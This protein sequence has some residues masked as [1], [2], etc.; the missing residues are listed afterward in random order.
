MILCF[1]SMMPIRAAGPA[2]QHAALGVN[3]AAEAF[4][5]DAFELNA[6]VD[7][8]KAKQA[9][10]RLPPAPLIVFVGS[11]AAVGGVFSVPHWPSCLCAAGGATSRCIAWCGRATR[12]PCAFGLSFTPLSM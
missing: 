1:L 8:K 12:L 7:V 5:L 4:D 11:T 10:T 3:A 6:I 2:Q 9:T